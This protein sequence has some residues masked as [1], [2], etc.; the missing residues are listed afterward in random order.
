MT[1]E[2]G[3]PAFAYARCPRCGWVWIAVAPGVAKPGTSRVCLPRCG[4]PSNEFVP[5]PEDDHDRYVPVGALIAPA[6][7][8]G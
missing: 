3:A 5:V 4:T 7:V 2:T 6:V 1:G 8:G